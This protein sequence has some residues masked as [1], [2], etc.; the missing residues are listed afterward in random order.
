MKV[1]RWQCTLRTINFSFRRSS[2]FVI[3]ASILLPLHRR[4]HL[5]WLFLDQAMR[6]AVADL[7][8]ACLTHLPNL[9]A[10][11][12]VKSSGV[13]YMWF[14]RFAWRR[15]S[16]RLGL[17]FRVVLVCPLVPLWLEV[18]DFALF[19]FA[20]LAVVDAGPAGGGGGAPAGGSCSCCAP[21]TVKTSPELAP[22]THLPNTIHPIMC[23]IVT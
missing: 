7:A 2:Y 21:Y 14:N 16:P 22:Y 15:W 5:K 12:Q 1:I 19:L 4:R 10:K 18:F 20:V 6:E 11:Y 23:A 17:E 13:V 9:L 8:E 3:S